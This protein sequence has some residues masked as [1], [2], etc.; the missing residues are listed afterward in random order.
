MAKNKEIPVG[1]LQI[2]PLQIFL[3]G[4]LAE[5][6]GWNLYYWHDLRFEKFQLEFLQIT[7]S[8]NSNEEF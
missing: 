6:K 3:W 1:N 7:E 5:N 8:I 2:H 4:I